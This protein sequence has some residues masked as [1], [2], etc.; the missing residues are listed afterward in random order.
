[1]HDSG[2]L[3][4]VVLN[5]ANHTDCQVTIRLKA[6]YLDASMQLLTSSSDVE[7]DGAPDQN[8]DNSFYNQVSR[9]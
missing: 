6:Q 9:G 8:M 3:R 5:K 2:E 1:M 7:V 4:I